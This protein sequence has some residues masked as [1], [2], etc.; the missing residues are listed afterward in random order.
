MMGVLMDSLDDVAR[1]NQANL[2]ALM[3]E[4]LRVFARENQHAKADAVEA[5]ILDALKLYRA[6]DKILKD[7][8]A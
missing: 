3:L 6:L 5:L 7:D 4:L 2:F 8:A 1:K